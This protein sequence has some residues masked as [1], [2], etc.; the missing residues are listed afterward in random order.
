MTA[1]NNKAEK[2]LSSA[3]PCHKDAG[4]PRC[5]S[6]GSADSDGSFGEWELSSTLSERVDEEESCVQ[7]LLVPAFDVGQ[8]KREKARIDEMQR[9]SLVCDMCNSFA[10]TGF[11]AHASMT[12]LVG[13]ARR[14]DLSCPS[15][16]VSDDEKRRKW[17]DL[18]NTITTAIETHGRPASECKQQLMN[19]RLFQP[20]VGTDHFSF[21]PHEA[22]MQRRLLLQAL[23]MTGRLFFEDE[24]ER[25][26]LLREEMKEEEQRGS[27]SDWDD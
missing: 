25:E 19:Y 4:A 5:N 8:Q 9:L 6:S 15:N 12:M 26:L 2:V 11:E 22:C 24:G 23:R 16:I 3:K 18:H 14:R 10:F 20:D 27:H 21:D 13:E 1:P 17:N 7:E